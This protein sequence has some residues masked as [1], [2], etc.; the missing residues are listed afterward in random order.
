MTVRR[1]WMGTPVVWAVWLSSAVAQVAP[2]SVTLHAEAPCP[3]PEKLSPLLRLPAGCPVPWVGVLY[4]EEEHA[5]MREGAAAADALAVARG[6]R[7]DAAVRR[8]DEC[9]AR[10]AKVT[11]ACVVG[12]SR[13]E[14]QVQA[15][16]A[17][18][19][20][21][22]GSPGVWPA[23]VSGGLAVAGSLA[24][25]AGDDRPT[26]I[27]YGGAGAVTGAALGVLAVWLLE[28]R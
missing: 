18:S 8:L 4:T 10:R 22:A 28:G 3:V 24:A 1:W 27:L 15:L 6:K 2:L 20:Q 26:S 19:A 9:R 11:A 16:S 25:F 13:I 23:V 21:P 17:L 12:V 5:R 14:G 7:A